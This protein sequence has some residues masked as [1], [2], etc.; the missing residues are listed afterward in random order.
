MEQFGFRSK[1]ST[2]AASYSLISEVLNVLNNKHIIRG[3][4][5][6]LTKVF[7]CFNHG[8]LLSKLKYY[9]KTGT[10]YSWIKSYIEDRHQRVKLVNNLS[11][12]YVYWTVHHCE[13]WRIKD[14]LDVTCYFIS[15][16]MGSTCFGH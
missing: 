6:D 9:G 12:S 2:K 10:F 7:D 11:P 16:L 14:Q 5:C 3:I 15:L 8:I 13:S 1:F 4:F